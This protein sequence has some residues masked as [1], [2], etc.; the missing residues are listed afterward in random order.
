MVVNGGCDGDDGAC[1]GD[2]G[3]RDGRCERSWAM[4]LKLPMRFH[5]FLLLRKKKMKSPSQNFSIIIGPI[6]EINGQTKCG[7][8]GPVNN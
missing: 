1:D 4:L 5:I 7:P 8:N 6:S 3:G 2:D